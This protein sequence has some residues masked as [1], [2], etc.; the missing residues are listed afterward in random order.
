MT[1][2][3]AWQKCLGEIISSLSN[4]VRQ[5]VDETPHRESIDRSECMKSVM[6]IRAA[7]DEYGAAIAQ[8]T[9]PKPCCGEWMT[10][11][12]QCLP[13]AQRWRSEALRLMDQPQQPCECRVGECES[14][15]DRLCRMTVEIREGGNQ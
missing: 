14:K 12:E 1:D 2:R 5:A 8:R 7:V 9:E 10:C 11:Q 6:R 3:E 13:L 15:Q 4:I